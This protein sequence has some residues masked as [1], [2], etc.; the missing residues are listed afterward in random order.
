MVVAVK[1]QVGAV[2]RQHLAKFRGIDQAAQAA[3]RFN[4]NAIARS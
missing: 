2:R 3:A 4:K 1:N